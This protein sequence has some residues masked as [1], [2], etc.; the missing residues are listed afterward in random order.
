M[1][2]VSCILA[3][4]VDT[5]SVVKAWFTWFGTNFKTCGRSQH[6][7]D[8]PVHGRPKLSSLTLTQ[9]QTAHSSLPAKDI[10]WQRIMRHL[11][12]E[13]AQFYSSL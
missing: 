9:S 10:G 2:K 12:A 8:K 7:P 1:Q 3:S 11:S 4:R 6:H 13:L 5:R